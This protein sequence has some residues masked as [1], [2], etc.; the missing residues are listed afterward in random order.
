MTGPRSGL[1]GAMWGDKAIREIAVNDRLTEARTS[2]VVG[3]ELYCGTH[4]QRE[5]N[6][7]G[8]GLDVTMTFVSALPGQP[9]LRRRFG[10]GLGIPVEDVDGGRFQDMGA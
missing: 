1:A 2:P 3:E 7:A 10:L 8:G 6:K 5:S 9:S 4:S